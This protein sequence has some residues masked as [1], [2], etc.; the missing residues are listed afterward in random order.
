MDWSQFTRRIF[1]TKPVEPIFECW[2]K[3]ESIERWFLKKANF[4]REDI[5]L[6][7]NESITKGDNYVWEWNGWDG[8]TSGFILDIKENSFINFEFGKS[9]KVKVSLEAVSANETQV[10]LNHYEIPTEEESKK[11]Y[12]VGCSNGWSFWLVNLKLFLEYDLL[13][14][15]KNNPLDTAIK[16]ELVNA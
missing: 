16:A 14:N 6:G 2:S 1:I 4:Y 13:I 12:H 3:A 15:H 8:Q 11:N 5:L 10:I 9:G 7:K